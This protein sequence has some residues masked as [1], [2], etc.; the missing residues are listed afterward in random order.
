MWGFDI[1]NILVEKWIGHFIFDLNKKQGVEI[2]VWK[3]LIK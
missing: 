2:D 1:G 3:F